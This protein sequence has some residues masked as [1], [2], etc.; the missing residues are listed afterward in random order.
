MTNAAATSGSGTRNIWR[1]LSASIAKP[2]I[3]GP[4]LGASVTAML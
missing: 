4:K 2:P 3:H 1:Q